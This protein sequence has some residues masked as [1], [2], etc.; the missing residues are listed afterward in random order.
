M[1]GPNPPRVNI[2]FLGSTGTVPSSPQNLAYSYDNVLEQWTFTFDEPADDG[3]KPIIWHY[4]YI[5]GFPWGFVSHP[6]TTFTVDLVSCPENSEVYVRA[7]NINGL[8]E[9]SNT[10]IVV[11]PPVGEEAGLGDGLGDEI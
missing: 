2:A 10:V 9:P 6:T 3:G 7:Y 4:L 1:I 5:G 11:I 8:S